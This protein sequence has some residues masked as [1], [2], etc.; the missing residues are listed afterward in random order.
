MNRAG[1]MLSAQSVQRPNAQVMFVP[2]PEAVF[3]PRNQHSTDAPQITPAQSAAAKEGKRKRGCGRRRKAE[4]Q[5]QACA[6][7]Q[8]EEAQRRR[9]A[10]RRAS[11]QAV[12]Q[13]FSR[14]RGQQ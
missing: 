11:Q 14:A 4:A 2:S 1:A 13:P 7:Q 6:R 9:N 5:S 3:A 8:R 10:A 12:D